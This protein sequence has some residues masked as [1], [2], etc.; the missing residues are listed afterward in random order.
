MET[1]MTNQII[2]T[3]REVISC[4]GNAQSVH[5]ASRR[6]AAVF[7]KGDRKDYCVGELRWTS[8]N[9]WGA[10][11][12]L[13]HKYKSGWV[14]KDC[15]C[16]EGNYSIDSIEFEGNEVVVR[17]SSHARFGERDDFKGVYRQ[18]LWE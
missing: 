2:L 7:P 17:Y 3:E 4:L 12:Y 14:C 16:A 15:F 9:Y 1:T 8:G 10:D 18:K 13:V 5:N 11:L 6:Y